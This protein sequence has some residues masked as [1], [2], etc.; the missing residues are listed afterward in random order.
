[1]ALIHESRDE[2][3]R[4][5]WP[6]LRWS[7]VIIAAVAMVWS[8]TVVV[9]GWK[10]SHARPS[11]DRVITAVGMVRRHLQPD[12]L[13]W[14]A[15]IS[16][17]AADRAAALHKLSAEM[18]D[19]RA[20]MAAHE[21]K[22]EDLSVSAAACSE[23]TETITH[24]RPDGSTDEESKPNGFVAT[25]KLELRATEL[26]RAIRAIREFA[27][28]PE[29]AVEVETD[30]PTC[31]YSDIDKVQ[32]EVLAAAQTSVREHGETSAKEIGHTKLGKLLTTDSGSFSAGLGSP[33]F[34][35][36]EHGADAIASVSARY[37]ID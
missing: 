11:E 7:A 3:K 2:L 32:E 36:C 27:A 5:G 16:A 29:L 17:H 24:H 10:A 23:D 8:V 26:P 35:A 9:D 4:R 19:V 21:I 14:D 37:Q 18:K 34:D 20:F 6:S 30:E 25:Q 13:L 33:S 1:M 12:R 22:P 28:A 31:S 15:T